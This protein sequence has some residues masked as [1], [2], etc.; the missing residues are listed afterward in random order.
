MQKILGET[1]DFLP[2]RSVGYRQREE[3]RAN[4]CQGSFR[5][6][7]RIM[8]CMNGG[9]G[10]KCADS[11]KGRRDPPVGEVPRVLRERD[12]QGGKDGQQPGLTGD[13]DMREGHHGKVSLHHQQETNRSRFHGIM[14]AKRQPE[15]MPL[16]QCAFQVHRFVGAVNA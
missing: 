8:R 12:T 5:V 15:L 16:M 14:P 9:V 2:D 7:A 11:Q 10:K 3:K 13:L 1:I 6:F 4:A